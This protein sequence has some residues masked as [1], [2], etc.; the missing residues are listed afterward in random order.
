MQE[1][2]EPLRPDLW[3]ERVEMIAEGRLNNTERGLRHAFHLLQ[4]T[5]R[6]FRPPEYWDLDEQGYEELLSAGD[7]E[8]AARRLVA[9]PTLTVTTAWGHER[10]DV[11]IRCRTLKITTFG[12]GD[13]VAAAILQCWA[14]CFLSLRAEFGMSGLNG[15]IQA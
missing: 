8:A 10:I 7:L 6:E 12:Q 15:S 1:D 4:L 3:F 9:A 2:L 11:A 13:S 5:P 14:K